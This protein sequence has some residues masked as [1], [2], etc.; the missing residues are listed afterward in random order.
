MADT[1]VK[2][3]KVRFSYVNIFQPRAVDGSTD[4]KYSLTLLVPKSDTVTIKAMRQAIK[5]AR[6]SKAEYFKDMNDDEI[7]TP[8]HDGD[9]RKPKGGAYGPECK[10]CWVVNTSS[11]TK[12]G[13][14]DIH[15]EP[16]IDTTDVYSGC[17]GRV[18]LNAYAYS[19]NGNKGISFGL[20]NVQKLADGAPLDGR[21]RAEDD[22][23]DEFV[24]DL[25]EEDDFGI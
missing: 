6:Q 4:A 12:P 2:T 18:T 1:K 9:G 19:R 14:V 17:Y 5:A 13:V 3:G 23:D 22:F 20:N 24:N 25:V 7:Q 11:K 8:I 10:G 15:K 21:T 16:I